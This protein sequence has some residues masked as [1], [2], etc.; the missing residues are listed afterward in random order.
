MVQ[1][2]T[3]LPLIRGNVN[4]VRT[5]C[6]W[7]RLWYVA[8]TIDCLLL[9]DDPQNSDCLLCPRSCKADR[10]KDPFPPPDSFLRACK[11]TEG[12]GW[13]HV[14]CSVFS[15][16]LTFTDASRLRLVEGLST[17]PHHRWATVSG[18]V[19]DTRS[20]DSSGNRDAVYVTC[21]VAL[22]LNV[23]TAQRIITFP[24]HGSKVT[25][26]ALRYNL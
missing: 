15:P 26:S 25:S 1:L 14:I 9:T 6:P 8:D 16:E 10:Q 2:W 19:Y 5:K 21:R 7:K 20:P 22:S 13:A 24:A 3:L 11:A 4:Y 23:A 18:M 12:Q 17:I